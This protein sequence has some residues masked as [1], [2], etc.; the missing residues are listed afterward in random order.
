MREKEN[1]ELRNKNENLEKINRELW[2]KIE[3]QE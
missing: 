2:S 3:N 1:I